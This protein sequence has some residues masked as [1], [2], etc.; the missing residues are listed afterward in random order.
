MS[1]AHPTLLW[2]A[3][4]YA[5]LLAYFHFK[6][7][8]ESA[9][10]STSA[11]VPARQ[12]WRTR[13]VKA[14]VPML[15]LSGFLLLVAMSGPQRVETTRNVVPSG[16]EIMIALDISGSMAAEDFQPLNRLE[17]AKD[18]LRDFIRARPS[19]RIGLIIFG[20]MSIT[21]SP[22][23]L[24]HEPLIR[25]VEAIRMGD[26]PEG[27][28]IG[29]AILNGVNRLS[30]KTAEAKGAR[31]LMLI[32]DGRNN[33]GEIH[34]LDALPIAIDKKIKIYTIGVGSFGAVPF[35][36]LKLPGKKQYVYEKA[37]LDEPLLRKIAESSG[38]KYFRASDPKSL[39]LLFQQINLLEKSEVRIVESRQLKNYGRAVA[40]P[41]AFLMLCY[42][43]LTMVIVRLP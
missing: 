15:V 10:L 19:D 38:G 13:T 2:L 1:F 5:L 42:I 14:L 16:I 11:F 6:N 18:V 31:I 7:R 12:T 20:G 9:S 41:T 34:P 8:S 22:L 4:V 24:Q 33:A 36:I 23:T 3:P 39:Q 17:V 30:A 37:D 21:R 32:T 35:P 25:T 28:A 26:V 43:V 40:T 29:Y 27:T